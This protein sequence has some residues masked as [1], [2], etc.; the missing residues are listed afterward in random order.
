MQFNIQEIQ[1]HHNFN[2]HEHTII[3][4]KHA[5]MKTIAARI[6]WVG[7]ATNQN[8]Q[9]SLEARSGDD[10]GTNSSD[11]WRRGT[12][13]AATRPPPATRY[14]SRGDAASSGGEDERQIGRAHV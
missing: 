3:Y 2:R 6:K 11:P 5:V 7:L 12:P 1:I 13:P 4:W 14:S 8:L 10:G 9:E